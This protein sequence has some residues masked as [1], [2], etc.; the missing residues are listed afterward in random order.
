MMPSPAQ[1]KPVHARFFLI[2]PAF[3]EG[4]VVGRIQIFNQHVQPIECC[5]MRG[6][7]QRN[8][9]TLMPFFDNIRVHPSGPDQ[10]IG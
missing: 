5:K 7:I 9:E 10:P 4:G 6:I 2:N 8:A 1:T 3:H